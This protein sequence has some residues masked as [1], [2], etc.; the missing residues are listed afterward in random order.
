[1]PDFRALLSKPVGSAKPPKILPL[2]L[3]PGVISKFEFGESQQN[4]T[5]YVRLLLTLTGW[6]E[7]VDEGDM[8]NEDG[9]R[10]EIN[11]RG[12]FRRDFYLTPDAEHRFHSFM[13][14][15][16]PDSEGKDAFDMVPQLVGLSVMV[17]IRQYT[18]QR[19]GELGN[20]VGNLSAAA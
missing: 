16:I 9:T 17:E 14:E 10:I 13:K 20:E 15:M 2:G 11:K 6:A 7:G 8:V 19:T 4:K 5:P 1:M 3:Y 12:P 18:S